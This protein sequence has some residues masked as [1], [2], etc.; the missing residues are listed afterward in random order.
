MEVRSTL[1]RDR[2]GTP[3]SVIAINTDITER[4]KLEEQLLR[5]QRMEGIGTL[6]GGIA[7][8]LNNALGPILLSIELLR[9]RFRDPSSQE[10]L[11]VI[12]GSAQRGADMVR[13]VLSFARGYE[14]E[15]IGVQ[16]RHLV[17]EME[18]MARE[19]FP[20]NIHVTSEVA[21][22]LAEVS[23]DPT[24]LHQV[25][26]NLCVNARDAMPNGGELIL[27]AENTEVDAH[28]AGL[29]PGM[30][31]GPYVLMRV[32]DTGTGIPPE[33]VTQI[34]DPFFTTKE[35]GKGTGLGLSTSLAIVKSHGGFL[36][37]YSE[38][39]RGTTFKV[40][41]PARAET[42][43]EVIAREE[44]DGMPRGHGELVLVIDDEHFVREITRQTLE[45]YGYKVLL[46]ESGAEAAILF[47][48][49][50]EKNPVVITDMRMPVMDG[51]ATIQ[52][53]R[54]LKPDV[55]IIA[56]SGLSVNGRVAQA[57][58]L[59]VSHFLPKPYTARSLLEM[60][61]KVI[62]GANDEAEPG[63]EREI[64]PPPSA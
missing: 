2:D 51:A 19:T 46:A 47:A 34:F 15:R 7:H 11:E 43:T 6:A 25:L 40:Y 56:V 4:K 9:N 61:R 60:L 12:A 20:G 33:I 53:L 63:G 41:L 45:E 39:G 24:Q 1:L 54:R 62:A 37:V 16:V 30:Q 22:D 59:G 55:R 31:A 49:H 32:E 17:R 29:N 64:S 14:G 57:A 28:Y 44:S 48:D 18:K 8:D 50:L 26:L 10:L 38:P 13:Q 23:G 35:V 21:P 36:H 42:S 58:S 52:V 3:K 27:S 5:A